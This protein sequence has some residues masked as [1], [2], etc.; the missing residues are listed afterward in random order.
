M[1]E[2]VTTVVKRDGTVEAYSDE[3]LV[4]SIQ[5]ALTDAESSIE[6]YVEEPSCQQI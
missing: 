1:N 5:R 6:D 2:H 3:K 4:R